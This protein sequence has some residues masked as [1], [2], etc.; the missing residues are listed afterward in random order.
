MVRLLKDYDMSVL[1]HPCKANV[2]VDALSHMTMGRVSRVEE[3]KKDL[4]KDVHKLA[5][6]EV[7]LEDSPNSGFIVHHNCESALVVEVKSK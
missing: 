5:R 1:Y 2:V 7:R 4:L 3:E 6:L